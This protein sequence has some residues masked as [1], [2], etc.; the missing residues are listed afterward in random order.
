MDRIQRVPNDLHAIQQLPPISRW[1]DRYDSVR[2]RPS[3]NLWLWWVRHRLQDPV[4]SFISGKRYIPAL[5]KNAG[6]GSVKRVVWEE[7]QWRQRCPWWTVGCD[8]AFA[9]GVEMQAH[10]QNVH[11]S[12]ND[13]PAAVGGEFYSPENWYPRG[14]ITDVQGQREYLRK[15]SV[16]PKLYQQKVRPG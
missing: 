1:A 13:R 4:R 11:L 15:L 7:N 14:R 6:Y 16:H 2:P 3:E 5:P 10:V 12:R 8:K 9:S